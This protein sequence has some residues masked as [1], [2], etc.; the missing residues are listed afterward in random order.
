MASFAIS[1]GGKWMSYIIKIADQHPELRVGFL[2][3]ASHTGETSASGTL[4]APIAAVHEFGGTIQRPARKQTLHFRI[5]KKGQ[6]VFAK[7]TSKRIN[8]TMDVDIGGGTS[9]IPPRPFMRR[10]V[11]EKK[12]AWAK[13]TAKLLKAHPDGAD[14]AMQLMGDVIAKDIQATIENSVP[15]PLKASTIA[16]K[17]RRGKSAPEKTLIDT[18]AMQEA[19]AFEVTG[20]AV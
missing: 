7:A 20:G 13:A 16:A 17:R 6:Q 2:E 1:G 14:A 5:N 8:K 10:T 18:G 3:G 15:P 12:N 19:V 11:E 9:V 4:V